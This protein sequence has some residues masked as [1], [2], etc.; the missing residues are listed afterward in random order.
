M[1]DENIEI[2]IVVDIDKCRST[3]VP[4]INRI[5]WIDAR[6]LFDKGPDI[7]GPGRLR[8]QMQQDQRRQHRMLDR[9]EDPLEQR[10]VA[11]MPPQKK[12]HQPP[13]PGAAPPP[14]ERS[15]PHQQ[16]LAT[17]L[18]GTTRLPLCPRG[19]YAGLGVRFQRLVQNTEASSL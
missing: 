14:V 11:A 1:T 6:R 17:H 5:E 3:I 18:Q 16:P 10:G 2:S 4:H 13:Q 15:M 12:P 19:G 9:A 8:Q 7:P